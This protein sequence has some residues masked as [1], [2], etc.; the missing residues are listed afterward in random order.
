MCG[1]M[2]EWMEA[3]EANVVVVHCKGGKGRTGTVISAWL[4]ESG[5]VESAAVCSTYSPLMC[6]IARSRRII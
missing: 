4:V 1:N 5:Q 6:I 2:K 3:D